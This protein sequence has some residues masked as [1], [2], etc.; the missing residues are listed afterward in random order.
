MS[1][2]VFF[3]YS[4]A[5]SLICCCCCYLNPGWK[6]EFLN[7]FWG[8]Q[9]KLP[10]Q[11]EEPSLW[12]CGRAP[13]TVLQERTV[14]HRRNTEISNLVCLGLQLSSG[15]PRT[16]RSSLVYSREH[17]Q[18]PQIRSQRLQ[19][20]AGKRGGHRQRPPV[21]KGVQWLSVCPT[22]TP[23]C[24]QSPVTASRGRRR[25][26][27]HGPGWEARGTG[28]APLTGEGF[29]PTGRGWPQTPPPWQQRWR[30]GKWRPSWEGAAAAPLPFHPQGFGTSPG[31]AW[32]QDLGSDRDGGSIS[33]VTLGVALSSPTSELLTSYPLVIPVNRTV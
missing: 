16:A 4:F 33:S 9:R 20:G 25:A 18:L 5:Q 12:M 22:G 7:C 17:S 3:L 2:R 31:R 26:T 24:G 14:L 11:P 21:T 10:T 23:E 8:Y 6:I 28:R 30:S 19:R 13:Y 1:S 27:E 29:A 32:C 15:M